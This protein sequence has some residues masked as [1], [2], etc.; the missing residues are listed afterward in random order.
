MVSLTDTRSAELYNG[1]NLLVIT[2]PALAGSYEINFQNHF[3]HSTKYDSSSHN[4]TPHRHQRQPA[5]RTHRL[6]C[7][8]N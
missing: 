1:E 2:D 5:R 6:R 7:W 8:A 3:A 4:Q